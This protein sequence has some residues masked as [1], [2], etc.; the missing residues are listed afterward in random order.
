[1]LMV[2][3]VLMVQAVRALRAGTHAGRTTSVGG[4]AGGVGFLDPSACQ[5]SAH[6]DVGAS[7][8]RAP[9]PRED[10]PVAW[11]NCRRPLASMFAALLQMKRTP[12]VSIL[13][14]LKS[15]MRQL[16]T[17]ARITHL[18]YCRPRWPRSELRAIQV[19]SSSPRMPSSRL[20]A[21]LRTFGYPF[22]RVR[23]A[24]RSR[25][26]PCPFVPFDCC[27]RRSAAG[28]RGG[29]S[30]MAAFARACFAHGRAAFERPRNDRDDCGR[31]RG[32]YR[33]G[34]CD[35]AAMPMSWMCSAR[36]IGR[37]ALPAL[38]GRDAAMEH[39]GAA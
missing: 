6:S 24:A 36:L 14:D 27:W 38:A 13:W 30:A 29:R 25:S 9:L 7:S 1:M 21:G 5:A 10:L 11:R 23:R 33:S 35:R 19:K 3:M 16:Q 2:L 15:S 22:A 26:R 28:T 39:G 31:D 20:M 32:R 12:A 37:K 8:R 17:I 18:C 4:H 34:T